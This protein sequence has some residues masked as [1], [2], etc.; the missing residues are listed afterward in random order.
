MTNSAPRL[1]RAIF[2]STLLLGSSHALAELNP[3]Q[4][5]IKAA[6]DAAQKECYELLHDDAME[7]TACI[8]AVLAEV[9]GKG[10]AQN[11]K[12]MGILYFAWIGANNSA[13][14]SL[15]G[16]EEAAQF[17]LPKLRKMQKQMKLSDAELCPTVAG[18]CKARVAQMERM[19]Q[20]IKDIAAAKAAKKPNK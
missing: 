12:R 18:E 1:L 20:D 9:K 13:R 4:M 19:E 16:S 6:A 8:N 7:Y 11:Q 14:L 10:Q 3:Q 5:A 15:P 2:C 17:F